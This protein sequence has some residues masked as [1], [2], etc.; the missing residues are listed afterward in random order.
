MLAEAERLRDLARREPDVVFLPART[1]A[2]AADDPRGRVIA[3]HALC[4]AHAERGEIAAARREGLRAL[5]QARRIGDERLA[6]ELQLSLVWLDIERGTTGAGAARL[7]SVWSRLAG[8]QVGRAHCLSGLGLSARGRHAAAVAALTS[9][10]PHL[11]GDRWWLANV[12]TARGVAA[13]YRGHGRA[14]EEDLLRARALWTDVAQPLRAASCTHNLGFVALSSGDVLRALSLFDDAVREG[15]EP[16]RRPEILLDRAE[17]LQL[18]GLHVEA[19]AVLERA[20]ALLSGAGRPARLAEAR[21]TL[22]RCALRMGRPELA[23]TAAE[24]ALRAFRRQG[25]GPWAAV[26]RAVQLRAELAQDQL[27]RLRAVPRVALRC[28]H[29]GWPVAA[30]ELRL[31]GALR[32]IGHGQEHLARRVLG[33]LPESRARG[34]APLRVLA[35]RARVLLAELD[36]D[37]P[38]LMRAAR[39]GFRVLFTHLPLLGVFEAQAPVAGMTVAFADHA[40]G[41]LLAR[42]RVNARAVLR[43]TERRRVGLLS[44]P[45]LGPAAPS[46]GPTPA[47]VD[48]VPAPV[49][50]VPATVD[51][52][53]ATVDPV[54]SLV[55][56]PPA[57][58]DPALATVDP[59]L[60]TELAALRA[61]M[62]GA[63]R[64][65]RLVKS[66]HPSVT[67]QEQRVRRRALAHFRA[68]VPGVPPTSAEL[69]GA[70]GDA[71]LLSF[72]VHSGLIWVVALSRAG[73]RL[74]RLGRLAEVVSDVRRLRFALSQ[75]V[76]GRTSTSRRSA[77]RVAR[78]VASQLDALLRPALGGDVPLVI[79][80][81]GALHD[82]PWA[83]LPSCRGRP[84]TTAPS[85][86][87]WIRALAPRPAPLGPPVWVAGPGLVHTIREA[88]ALHARH[89]GR[90]L[91]GSSS[92]VD[93]VLHAAEGAAILHVA[94]HG[95]FRGDQPLLSSLDMADG[96]L[97]AYDL[98]RLRRAPRLVVLSAC[99]VGSSG[100]R[101]GDE[102]LG[103]AS[104]LLRVGTTA[105]V[106]SVLPVPDDQAPDL[107]T[108]LH[109]AT[110]AGRSPAEALAEAQARHGH[111]GFQCLGAGLTPLPP[112]AF[113]G[114]R[115]GGVSEGETSCGDGQRPVRPGPARDGQRPVRR[116]RAAAPAD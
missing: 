92:T 99:E 5:A 62:M 57:P 37:H 80:P 107:M 88:T 83:A 86:S 90:L 63:R 41:S 84:L 6:V 4:L 115:G 3:R 21:L 87:D 27:S 110:R 100:V 50:P 98:H 8:S 81:T 32:A 54:S 28:E 56:P 104:A 39:E 2:E 109:A 112:S 70:L 82:L 75:Q 42:P 33:R 55:D 74:H 108:A 60:A 73:A 20:C 94:A 76:I 45:P 49:D 24:Q 15:L 85:T 65:H 13:A 35:W 34:P 116:G 53:L 12:L 97:Y 1:L 114:G 18:A 46:A 38:R 64:A 96:P 44:R 103:L 52:A 22:A 72:F 43:W 16:R 93:A 102:L 89:G 19:G 31:D 95:T 7:R 11:D 29:Q 40:L 113:P 111:L 36:G 78:A 66:A 91:T 25:R 26:A 30:A 61:T 67:R 106:A 105:L 47:P 48:L 10:L 58:V 71:T 69:T 17:A 77:T 51:P 101:V 9:A 59:A 68:G 14:A 23:A 79:V